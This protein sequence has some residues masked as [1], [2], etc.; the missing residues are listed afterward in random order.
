[1]EDGIIVESGPPER[2]FADPT[3]QATRRFLQRIVD[4]G[5]L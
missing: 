4:A 1:V 3:E 5:R 2:I